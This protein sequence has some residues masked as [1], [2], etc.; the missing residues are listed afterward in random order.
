M[1][2][3]T[4]FSCG[5]HQHLRIFLGVTDYSHPSEMSDQIARR[6]MLTSALRTHQ[7]FLTIFAENGQWKMVPIKPR[8]ASDHV[9]VSSCWLEAYVLCCMKM[10]AIQCLREPSSDANGMG[11]ISAASGSQVSICPSTL[12]GHS[13]TCFFASTFSM[14]GR[15]DL[16]A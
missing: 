12:R 8:T 7:E 10:H 15:L 2:T 1:D 6:G 4:A 14:Q 9:T 11:F 5:L 16:R 13:L 3:A